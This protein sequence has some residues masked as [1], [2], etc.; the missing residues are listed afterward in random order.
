VGSQ[1]SK[2]YSEEFK[3][4]AIALARSSDNS[5]RTITITTTD[6]PTLDR[7]PSGTQVSRRKAVTP[8]VAGSDWRVIAVW[9]LRLT[10]DSRR[11]L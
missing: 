3:R 2:R 10:A 11:F 4:D 8:D 5:T 6:I 9:S 1:Y 7:F